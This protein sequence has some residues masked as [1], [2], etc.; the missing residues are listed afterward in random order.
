MLV[1]TEV[2]YLNMFCKSWWIRK[3]KKENIFISPPIYKD[4]SLGDIY[5]PFIFIFNPSLSLK[6]LID[7][8]LLFQVL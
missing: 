1:R 4:L 5:F 3:Y 7:D 6:E 2:N 8:V